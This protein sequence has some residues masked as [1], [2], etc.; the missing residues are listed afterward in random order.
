MSSKNPSDTV[1]YGVNIS[2][3]A[4]R[5]KILLPKKKIDH[6][7]TL[8]FRESEYPCRE[9]LVVS[10]MRKKFIGSTRRCKRPM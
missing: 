5:K 9:M 10:Q 2:M 7:D 1:I 4:L 8:E 6:F 3:P